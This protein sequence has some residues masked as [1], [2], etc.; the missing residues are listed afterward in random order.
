MSEEAAETTT[1]AT[2]EANA[3]ALDNMRPDW[4]LE[5]FKTVDDQAQAYVELN[6]TLG[7]KGRELSELKQSNES[8]GKL[9]G[10]PDE[11]YELPEIEGVEFDET[12][13]LLQSFNKL[14][15]ENNYTQEHY[16]QV[17]FQYAQSQV[18]E[19]NAEQE[20]S[21]A[22]MSKLENGEKRIETINNWI[23]ANVPEEHQEGLS[24]F[25]TSAA[26]VEAL[27]WLLD[28]KAGKA[29]AEPIESAGVPTMSQEEI[30]ELQMAVDS[31][32]ERKMRDPKYA[33]KIHKMME[34]H[35]CKG[36]HREFVG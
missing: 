5:K 14:A 16:E 23:G 24:D 35:V 12:S 29:P 2:T 17:L 19:H 30:Y 34:R 25:A 4:H 6:K 7:D 1:E 15:K 3:E 8:L 11:G 10:A 20:A 18:D 33:A 31:K 22:E 28:N 21:E 13:A 32:G 27:E 36:Q 26:A 9:Y